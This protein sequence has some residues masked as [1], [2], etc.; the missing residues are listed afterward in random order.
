MKTSFILTAFCILSLSIFLI[1]SKFEVND[2]DIAI[3]V[4]E[5]NDSYSFSAHY[6]KSNTS[7][8]ESYINE[9]ISPNSLA[10]SAN[11]YFNVSTSLTDKT[12]FH[13]IE[14]P[15]K[16]EITLDKRKNTTASYYRIKKMCEGVKGLLAGR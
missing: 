9:S 6:P 3:T 15:G 2:H 11:D 8:V 5:S 16:L 14:N 7:G 4:N 12:T 1:W 13:I 10:K